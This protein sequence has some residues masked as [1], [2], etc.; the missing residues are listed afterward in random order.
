MPSISSFIT[1]DPPNSVPV[2]PTKAYFH[3]S[4]RVRKSPTIPWLPGG[5]KCRKFRIVSSSAVL[6]PIQL[7]ATPTTSNSVG[8]N[9]RK[10]LN[11]MA[12][13][14]MLHRGYTRPSIR[15]TRLVNWPPRC[16]NLPYSCT[17]A[18]ES[19]AL[20]HSRRQARG[21]GR[22]AAQAH[23]CRLLPPPSDLMG[24]LPGTDTQHGFR[25]YLDAV[26]R[27]D[28]VDV[29][30]PGVR[31]LD[32]DQPPRKRSR[33]YH[34][35]S[36]TRLQAWPVVRGL[37]R[38][39]AA[40]RIM[41]QRP[42]P[43]IPVLQQP[44]PQ[45][46]I[47]D[48][49]RDSPSPKQYFGVRR[50]VLRRPRGPSRPGTVK[51]RIAALL[52]VRHVH[53]QAAIHLG[54]QLPPRAQPRRSRPSAAD[55][56][57]ATQEAFVY[58]KC[59]QLDRRFLW[60]S[61]FKLHPVVQRRPFHKLEGLRPAL[62][63]IIQQC[64]PDLVALP[65]QPQAC[66]SCPW[67]AKGHHICKRTPRVQKAP[68]QDKQYPVVGPVLQSH[69]HV[70]VGRVLRHHRQCT[71]RRGV[72]QGDKSRR[73]VQHHVA[74]RGFADRTNFP[75]RMPDGTVGHRAQY[76]DEVV[77]SVPPLH[78][79]VTRIVLPEDEPEHRALDRMPGIRRHE[80]VAV[81]PSAQLTHRLDVMLEPVP[82]QRVAR[83]GFR[84]DVKGMHDPGV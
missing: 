78:I 32:V 56:A 49:V 50:K 10:T 71:E 48:F 36:P 77:P 22:R 13:E 6:L 20:L 79:G 30:H 53:H 12:C 51:Q 31:V 66:V 74:D 52:V 47:V 26:L 41:R 70:A 75:L 80:M 73:S 28:H 35:H 16:R 42:V 3:A 84:D 45:S 39:V 17:T 81:A 34:V 8:K 44:L 62:F 14:I 60:V 57:P 64:L 1:C 55:A 65:K 83:P 43:V 37:E 24:I 59:R 5:R 82:V 25:R 33:H 76:A 11:A 58:R 38:P 69:N 68:R 2:Q 54:Y 23:F 63:V 9:A 15:H 27:M 7:E 18:L 72:R 29:R 46:Q 19:G 4:G 40:L 67:H 21:A 61:V